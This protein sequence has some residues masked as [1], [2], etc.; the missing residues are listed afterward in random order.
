MGL[1]NTHMSPRAR[2]V[3]RRTYLRPLNEDGTVF[4]TPSDM[5]DRVISHQRWLW[6]NQLKR[7]L[8]V[9]EEA[10]LA[11]LRDLMDR[12]LVT[13]S[14]RV[15]WMGG[16]DLVKERS[17]AAFNCSFTKV[18]NPADLVD[19]FWLL[20]QGCGV[21]FKPVP[22]LLEGFNPAVQEIEIIPSVRTEKGGQEHTSET[23]EDGVWTITVGDS[24]KSW[25]K[26]L[27]KLM[28]GKYPAHKIVIDLSQLRPAGKRLKGYGWLSS[29]WKPLEKA[30]TRIAK[31]MI[32]AGGR[33]LNA[34]EI[35]D[36]V[37]HLGTVL[38]SRRSAQIWLHDVGAPNEDAFVTAKIGRYENGN[39][40]REQSN[41]SLVFWQKPERSR[42]VDL[43]TTILEGGEPGFINGAEAKRRAPDFEGSNPCAE[44][45]LPSKGF[46]NLVQV[47]WHRFNGNLKGLLRAQYIAGR[48]NYRQTCVDMK[49]GVLQLAWDNNQH[50]L[51][52]CGVAPL[53]YVSWEGMDSRVMLEQ[54]R[55]AAING[56]NSMADELGTPRPRRVTQ[57]QPGGTSSKHLGLEGDEVHEGAHLALSRWVFNNIGV[58]VGEPLL[59][60]LRAAN[61]RVQP[62]PFDPAS[63]LVTIPVE[64][65]ASPLF[66]KTT[67]VIDGQEEYVEINAETAVS[68]LDRYANLMR[69]YVDHNCS[70]TV[71]FDEDEIDD[72][73]DWF[74]ANWDDYVGVSF[75]KRNDPTKTAADL[76]FSYLPQETV[77]KR[78]YDEYAATLLPLDLSTDNSIDLL[79]MG[80][81]ATG[82]CPVR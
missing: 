73:A 63:M 22:G 72:M 30:Y 69:Y 50:L 79:D 28:A 74:M 29:G 31:L 21:G 81:C 14:G 34:I 35:G 20:L 17:S 41:N 57:V 1:S 38:S 67:M 65:P 62:H 56:A 13:M 39:E 70:I 43:L 60:A 64:Y 12:S 27:G 49:D 71:S 2:I 7:T 47:V 48:A 53:G 19:V 80:D 11:E 55:D 16:T 82:A 8:S 45:L 76:G 5:K 4:E 26:S 18:E 68:Q 75:L 3:E 58:S 77:S 52:L 32:A 42:I 46:C 10:E 36:I 33:I 78:M 25:A 23:F 66:T 37:N 6:E 44:I 61:Y 15:K 24:A 54:V 40:H 51:R 59:D 9:T